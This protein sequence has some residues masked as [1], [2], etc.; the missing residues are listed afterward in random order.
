MNII[1][2]GKMGAGK[3]S[4]CEFF[5]DH[6]KI[7]FADAIRDTVK[8]LRSTDA[9]HTY[10]YLLQFGSFPRSLQTD[11]ALWRLIPQTQKDR[12]ILQEVGMGIRKYDENIWVNI[13]KQKI[14]QHKQYIISDCRYI[15]EAEAFDWVKVKVEA[16]RD[17]RIKRLIA[18]D[19]N[20][21]YER[22]NHPAEQQI[23][24]IECDLVINNNG[25]LEQLKG[26]VECLKSKI[27]LK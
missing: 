3:D 27:E 11:L 13:L 1:L 20:F 18:R 15:C 16:D 23:D 10:E 5:P 2:V 25:T 26:V 7:A 24:L 17:K 9:K 8:L 4:I 19:G 12:E 22:E 21:P 6:T 14:Y